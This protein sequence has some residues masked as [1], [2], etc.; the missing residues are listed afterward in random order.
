MA[1]F[2]EKTT[3]QLASAHVV[4]A[5]MET[6]QNL[7]PRLYSELRDNCGHEFEVDDEMMAR[8]DL[9]LA[10]IALD[11]QALKNLFPKEQAARLFRWLL[12]AV[13][14]PEYGAYAKQ[15]I[16][17][18]Q[19][20]FETGVENID[21]CEDPL[22]SIAARLLHRWLGKGLRSFEVK[23]AE[24]GSGFINP[25]LIM[26]VQSI[27]LS[28][29]GGWKRI[30]N[31]FKLE[32]GDLPVDYSEVGLED[33]TNELDEVRP[34]GTLIFRDK[35]GSMHESWAPPE[36]VDAWLKSVGAQRVH[37]VLVKGAWRGIKQTH[38]RLTDEQAKKFVDERLLACS[39]CTFKK[40]V[41][42]YAL[43]PKDIWDG[44]DAD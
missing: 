10:A 6:V 25:M 22:S 15:E 17:E 3:E 5:V 8:F 12:R 28:F 34:D 36:Q 33:F 13:D 24:E 41:P 35:D 44:F 30:S 1:L 23:T 9:A 42:E 37:K 7:W 19:Q 11:A 29:S 14:S 4:T 2:K 38:L 20:A 31:D 27:L 21:G 26:H 18:Y 43:V 40:G 32:E 39:I 16:H